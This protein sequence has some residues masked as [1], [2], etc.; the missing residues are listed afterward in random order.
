MNKL[1]GAG[2]LLVLAL[3]W[4]GCDDADDAGTGADVVSA[5]MAAAAD[6]G[7][8]IGPG[9]QV[10]DDGLTVLPDSS[11][12]GMADSNTIPQ[13]LHDLCADK[14]TTAVLADG[15]TCFQVDKPTDPKGPYCVLC[16][17][18]GGTQKLCLK[19]VIP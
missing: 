10:P 3:A 17:L 15:D 2:A 5:D 7:P 12:V 8:V 18:K 11:C 16:G 4:G 13:A 9:D 19:Q 14:L 1:M 6:T